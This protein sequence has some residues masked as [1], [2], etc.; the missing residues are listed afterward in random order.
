VTA[1]LVSVVI[2]VFNGERF[3][4]AAIQS[5]LDQTYRPVEVIVVDDGSTDES[6]AIARSFPG[7]RVIEQENSGPGTARN[8]AIAAAD[9][10]LLAFLDADDL[11]PAAKLERQV[12]HLREH[13]G[14]GCVL[15]R[16]EIFT[17]GGAPPPA[18]ALAPARWQEEHPELAE[19]G[20]IQPLSVVAW[21]WVF[22]SVGEFASGF[23][24]DVDWLCRVWGS[25]VQVDT[26]DAV[27]VRR[28]MHDAN[29]THD[30]GASRLAMFRAL[31]GHA[32]RS[33]A[34]GALVSVV[35][36]VF[37]GERFLAAAI[38]S[39]LDQTYRPVEVIVVDDGSTDE[40]GSIARSFPGVRVIEQENSGPAAARNRGVDA[41]KGG[42]VA[43]LDADDVMPADKLAR[44]V[45]H[46]H[47]HPG[48]GCVIGRQE[49]LLE[50][51]VEQPLWAE[52]GE[53]PLMSMVVRASLFDEIGG[54]DTSYVHGEDADWLL[55]AR[56][57][58]DVATLD[59]V[60]VRRRLHDGNLSNDVRALRRG[61]FRVLRD[62]MRRLR[63]EGRSS[64]GRASG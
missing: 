60:V 51:G 11:M 54:F 14:V 63:A 62:H 15:G 47:E 45:G 30:T 34:A 59:S 8:R 40:S 50:E 3:L 9:G 20:V 26:I 2:P 43:F 53:A 24:E 49:L 58:A 57:R 19:R 23:G 36:P 56:Q 17:E 38:Q 28:R 39:V 42:F 7:V 52:D 32:E 27:V 12:G 64:S 21:R 44:Q 29:L 18:W 13:P 35:I 48:V 4:A 6:A 22:D 37:N 16:Q 1:P 41:A 61:T 46:L 33:R 31:K 10:E 55:R 5:V 25:D